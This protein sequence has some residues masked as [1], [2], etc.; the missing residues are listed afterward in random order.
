M[1]KIG[2]FQ[3]FVWSE[4]PIE[5]FSSNLFSED[6]IHKIAILDL[7]IL[8]LDRNEC[9]ILVQSSGVLNQDHVSDFVN[10]SES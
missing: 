7:R 6:E 8:N 2:S 9:N 5:N 1:L 3:S 4:G 10:K